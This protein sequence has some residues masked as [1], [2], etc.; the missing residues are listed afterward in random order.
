MRTV[1]GY[2]PRYTTHEAFADFATALAPGL[3]SAERVAAAEAALAGALSPSGRPA[4]HTT[5]IGGDRA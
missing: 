4:R 1:L 2:H 5:A 3:L